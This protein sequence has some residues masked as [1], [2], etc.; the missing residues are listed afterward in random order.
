MDAL[1]NIPKPGRT[2]ETARNIEMKIAAIALSDPKEL[3]KSL[4]HEQ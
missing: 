1:G 2:K 3:E 4:L